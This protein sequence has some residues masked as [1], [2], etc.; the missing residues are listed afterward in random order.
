[1]H[2]RQRQR[3]HIAHVAI[4]LRAKLPDL[5]IVLC[6]GNDTCSPGHTGLPKAIKAS[7]RVDG[8][9]AVPYFW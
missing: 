1:V 2:R 8:W 4:W 3:R 5:K 7:R 9:L 6:A